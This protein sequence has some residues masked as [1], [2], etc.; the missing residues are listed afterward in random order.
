MKTAKELGLVFSFEGECLH[1]SAA[2]DDAKSLDS[3]LDH[4][5][6]GNIKS[7]DKKGRTILH[8]AAKKGSLNC[9]KL[10]LK[11]GG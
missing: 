3:L 4:G 8:I 7:T 6:H 9:V 1:R 5:C 11:R 2:L 10:L